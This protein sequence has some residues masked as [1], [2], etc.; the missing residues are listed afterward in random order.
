VAAG[1]EVAAPR[2]G[3]GGAWHPRRELVLLR[4]APGGEAVVR[5]GMTGAVLFPSERREDA[6]EFLRALTGA[7][8]AVKDVQSAALTPST[9]AR[10]VA[11]FVDAVRPR[12]AFDRVRDAVQGELPETAAGREE[13]LTAVDEVLAA[14]R[15]P[16]PTHEHLAA[17][18]GELAGAPAAR[19][20]G[21]ALH[22]VHPLARALALAESAA[23]R[24]THRIAWLAERLGTADGGHGCEHVPR[25]FAS[26]VLLALCGRGPLVAAVPEVLADESLSP[27]ERSWLR[28]L[29]GFPDALAAPALSTGGTIVITR[30]EALALPTTPGLTLRTALFEA[31]VGDL[32]SARSRLGAKLEAQASARPKRT[33]RTAAPSPDL[34][35]AQAV[36]FLAEP[37]RIEQDVLRASFTRL[38]ETTG[39]PLQTARVNRDDSYRFREVPLHSLVHHLPFLELVRR[40][41]DDRPPATLVSDWLWPRRAPCGALSG[42]GEVDDD[43]LGSRGRPIRTTVRMPREVRRLEPTFHV[44]E[45]VI[46]PLLLLRAALANA[47]DRGE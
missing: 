23:A 20:A 17:P 21:T 6:A 13:L 28:W 8:D 10:T 7:D 34:V 14:Y 26:L 32:A 47:T 44:P 37:G 9:V 4:L 1:D 45:T 5:V 31:A 40:S 36:L 2:R 27:A 29:D 18:L 25:L 19:L 39:A 24:P 41:L 43:D 12:T 22:G 3:G 46:E 16:L 33:S 11:S 15:A 30:A 42:P 35:L 38:F